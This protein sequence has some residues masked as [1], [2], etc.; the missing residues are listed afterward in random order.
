M[1]N[2]I[3][4][5]M[6]L[7][8]PGV[9][10]EPGPTY[11]TDVNNSLTILDAHSH[12]AGSGVLITPAAI[13]VNADLTL[14]NNSLTSIKSLVLTSQVS[15]SVNSSLYDFG[16]NLHFIDGNGTDIP[17]TAGG[18]VNS[19]SSGISSGTATAAFVAGVLVVNS[20]PLTP[21]DIQG[22]SVLFGNNVAS[23]NFLTLQPPNAMAASYSLTLPTLPGQNSIMTLDTSGNMGSSVDLTLAT[24]TASGAISA[25][26][27]SASTSIS[28]PSISSN[29]QAVVTSNDGDNLKITT[30]RISPAATGSGPGFTWSRSGTGNSVT[31]IAF[32]SFFTTVPT[33]TANGDYWDGGAGASQQTVCT[34]GPTNGS[35]TTVKTILSVSGTEN[36]QPFYFIAIG[37]R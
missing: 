36:T 15:N 8:I 17:I 18:V 3:S 25:D 27:V 30:G 10:T 24:I 7:I 26:T 6:A 32:N 20:A 13:N 1:A 34:I 4:P 23:S 12:V 37:A 21:A 33:V 9:G 35:L 19:T 28:S 31:T 11:A 2:T 16:G 22:G 14:S 5:N 29:G